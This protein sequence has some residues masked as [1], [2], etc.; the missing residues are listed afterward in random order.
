MKYIGLL[1]RLQYFLPRS[2]LLTVYKSFIGPHLNYGNVMWINN[3]YLWDCS[4]VYLWDY[5]AL[6]KKWLRNQIRRIEKWSE[7]LCKIKHEILKVSKNKKKVRVGSSSN[8]WKRFAEGFLRVF[9]FPVSCFKRSVKKHKPFTRNLRVFLY[10]NN[11]NYNSYKFSYKF[12]F[13]P[14]FSFRRN[15]KQESN[16]QQDCSLVTKHVSVFCF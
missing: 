11:R 10:G 13:I 14:F 2:S 9:L 5:P 8:S 15:Q 12:T 4:M 1:C 3:T 16:F 7:I 6:A